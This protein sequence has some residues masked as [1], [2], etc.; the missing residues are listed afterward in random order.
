M[1]KAL[2]RHDGISRGGSG[3]PATPGMSAFRAFWRGVER[4]FLG[5]KHNDQTQRN[6]HTKVCPKK[7]KKNVGVL[8]VDCC[9]ALSFSLAAR[10]RLLVHG[11]TSRVLYRKTRQGYEFKTPRIILTIEHRAKRYFRI[12]LIYYR[13][14]PYFCISR[15]GIV[16]GYFVGRFGA[17][18]KCFLLVSFWPYKCEVAFSVPRRERRL[19][20]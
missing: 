9:T 20:S 5:G 19:Y 7:K 16:S 17:D 8:K 1:M 13:K 11:L 15:W 4:F 18:S 14:L 6:P 10:N 2:F 12:I 3:G